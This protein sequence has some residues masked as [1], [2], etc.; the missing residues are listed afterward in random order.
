VTILLLGGD[1]Q[2]GW[3]LRRTLAPLGK[4]VALER[5]D[6][7]LHADLE[8]FASLTR[9][10]REVRPAL[11][12]N[13]AAYTAVDRAEAEPDKAMRIN[14]EA[15]GILA[16]LA[17][18][19]GAGL[20][21]Y[22]TDYVFPGD[23]EQPYRED[24]PTGPRSVY[25]QSK[26][27]GEAAIRQTGATHLILRTA[28]VYGGRGRNF[29]L[30]MLRLM[31]EREE[32]GIVA[33]QTG[34]PTWSRLIAEATAL[35]IARRMEDGCP[36]PEG[37]GGLYHL[38]CGGQTTWFGFAS[39][40]R[41]QALAL[42]LLHEPCARIQPITTAEYPTPARRP[43]FSVLDCGKLREDFALELPD[44]ESALRLCLADASQRPAC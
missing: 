27:A 19:Q 39:A 7:P 42:S 13:A 9:V 5:N 43:P 26:L 35:I 34:A 10:V 41:E 1:G 4:V 12:V 18:E 25:G 37:R 20:I 14:G 23:A 29:L 2:V 40:I 30:T 38:T 22:S 33:D 32:V 8:D 16:E 6:G 44:W 24:D 11:I 36:I 21:H 3:E 17:M 31:R 28:W 15:P